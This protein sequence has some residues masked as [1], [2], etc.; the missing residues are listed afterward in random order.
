M[1]SI[2]IAFFLS[3]ISCLNCLAQHELT[4]SGRPKVRHFGRDIFKGD[5]QFWSACEN[6]DGIMFFGNNDGIVI[7]DGSSWQTLPLP[8][9]SSVRGL[10]YSSTGTVYVAGFGHFGKITRDKYGK[11]SLI[12]MVDLI[13]AKD[14]DFENIWDIN[15]H[16]GY[17]IFRSFDKLLALK[18]DK[19]TTIQSSGM[20][21]AN[22]VQ[23]NYYVADN[24]GLKVLDLE[25]LDFDHILTKEELNNDDISATLPGRDTKE[26]LIIT[27]N[28]SAYYLKN[29]V[30][31]PLGPLVKEP[32]QSKIL[33]AIK[34]KDG[35]YHLGTL[36]NQLF[37]LDE[38]LQVI[39]GGKRHWN[40]QDN[41]VLNLFETKKGNVWAMLN[42]GLDMLNFAS[43]STIIQEGAS[44]FDLLISNNNLYVATNQGVTY[45]P[46]AD[47]N[48]SSFRS[49][50]ALEGQAWS[51]QEI[52]GRILCSHNKGL[53]E[54]K[55]NQVQRIGNFMGVWK[56]VPIREDKSK[57]LV[58][59]Y[60]G[61]IVLHFD[62]KKG[63]IQGNKIADFEESSRD[64]L[65]T[66]DPG[67]FWICH[68]YKGVYRVKF[69]KAYQKAIAIEHYREN[70]L[71]SPFNIN[72]FKWNDQT[73]FTTNNGI[74]QFDD[75]TNQFNPFA[76]LNNVLGNDDNVRTLLQAYDQT[77]FVRDD[78]L[79]YLKPGNN[80]LN[81]GTFL[82]LKGSFNRS[83]ECLFPL[84]AENLLVGTKEG[85]YAYDLK[86]FHNEDV[87]TFIT[88][89]NYSIDDILS[90]AELRSPKDLVLPFHVNR[91]TFTYAA[92]GMSDP[93]AVQFRYRLANHSKVWSDWSNSNET[94]FTQLGP[95]TYQ[96]EVESRSLI[97]E[98]GSSV[99]Y[100]FKI[101][102]VWYKTKWAVALYFI[103]G[104]TFLLVGRKLVIRKINKERAITQQEEREK[105]NI[106]ELELER[107][108]L[109]RERDRIETEK[110][111]LE[112]DVVDKSKE[113]TN[114]TMLLAR[115]RELI[116]EIK[117]E[118]KD[119]KEAARNEN[120]RN[121]VRN[122]IRK[123]TRH[124]NDEEYIKVFE[125]NFERVHKE[126]FDELKSLF[127]DLSAKEMRLCAL[128]RMNLTNK[129][130]APILNI[131][132]RGVETARYRLR[133]RLTIDHDENMVAFLENLAGQEEEHEHE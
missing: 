66:D 13:A 126:F 98:K 127:P 86:A 84:S 130:I 125:T 111:V 93:E 8:N 27:Q 23:D 74:F 129:E 60:D 63:F 104:I 94:Q 4:V 31:T 38:N 18:N 67:V 62:E 80:E 45:N 64:I 47:K 54:V 132:I 101:F 51:I 110:R 32:Q 39:R 7:F 76:A 117:D 100:T 46:I 77:W 81:T 112:E 25:T 11:W 115:K 61:I 59:L 75:N 122:I 24:D 12:S 1:R 40:L 95:G 92:P 28:S 70:G 19:I 48:M 78:M 41:T 5:T 114:Y 102:P 2:L 52:N 105:R 20:Y 91:V 96:F 49:I 9:N 99:S 37:L 83:M 72:V 35:N 57:F 33:S 43:Q 88:G 116:S 128:V 90:H 34:S 79:G 22:T 68:G 107:M 26:T 124:L 123:I 42:D 73:V 120:N 55:G 44:V 133:K 85:L 121:T 50:D 30:L 108:K 97:G 113:L 3:V 119:L 82:E 16:Q 118:L 53:F 109:E 106:L 6:D 69:D 17:V 21:Y 131:S 87:K 10:L 89:I 15:E 56:V 71:P 14:R 29:K 65:Q 36:N 103:L 58:C